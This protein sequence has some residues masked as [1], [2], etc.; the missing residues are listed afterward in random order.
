MVK[1]MV[2]TVGAI[3][4]LTLVTPLGA[5]RA[6]NSPKS[7]VTNIAATARCTGGANTTANET[8]CNRPAT[9]D[10][11]AGGDPH[12][13]QVQLNPQPL[14]PSTGNPGEMRKSGG[15][16]NAKSTGIIIEGHSTPNAQTGTATK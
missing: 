14:P 15:D 5:P 7:H 13:V 6:E 2:M 16:P 8:N 10:R 9:T 1:F 12:G 4:A 3:L 11:K